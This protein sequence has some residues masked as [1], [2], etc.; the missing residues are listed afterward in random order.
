MSFFRLTAIILFAAVVLISCESITSRTESTDRVVYSDPD[1]W[2]ERIAPTIALREVRG[3][4]VDIDDRMIV[5]AESVLT[6]LIQIANATIPERE[7]AVPLDVELTVILRQRRFVQRFS[8]R[9]STTIEFELRDTAGN[10]VSRAVRTRVGDTG[11]MSYRFLLN[12]LER[13]LELVLDRR[14]R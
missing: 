12:E 3:A 5:E 9:F 10:E 8:E 11:F 13:T 7:D 14:L 1:A 4:S 2:S 6:S